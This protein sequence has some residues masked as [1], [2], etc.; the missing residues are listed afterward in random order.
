MTSCIPPTGLRVSGKLSD[1]AQIQWFDRKATFE[2]IQNSRQN[3]IQAKTLSNQNDLFTISGDIRF[4]KGNRRIR[5]NKS[6]IKELSL[7]NKLNPN[8]D[9]VLEHG[10]GIEGKKIKRLTLQTGQKSINKLINLTHSIKG[11]ESDDHIDAS[12]TVSKYSISLE[13]QGGEDTIIGTDK[14]DLIAASTTRDACDFGQGT[15]LSM[16]VKDV[17]TGGKGRD[18]FFADNGTTITDIEAAERIYIYNH[19]SYDLTKLEDISPTYEND[20]TT[21]LI[22]TGDIQITTNTASFEYSFAYYNTN[23]T[24]CKVDSNGEEC[25]IPAYPGQPEG[26]VLTATEAT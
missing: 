13:G 10:F 19:S 23:G 2:R 7:T 26:Y 17:L 3:L 20:G 18:Y 25:E 15:D 22:K 24:M 8:I 4:K 11:R 6:S 5:W 16:K 1:L 12:A 14:S 9:F 21:T